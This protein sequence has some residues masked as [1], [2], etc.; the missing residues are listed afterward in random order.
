MKFCINCGKKLDDGIMFCTGCGTRVEEPKPASAPVYVPMTEMYL[1][2]D[3]TV[4]E[5]PAAK[6]AAAPAPKPA[7]EP[8]YAYQPP[9]APV[10]QPPVQQPVAPAPKKPAA[11]KKKG[12]K[13]PLVLA[14]AGVALLVVIAVVVLLL[15]G[16][17][18]S[19]QKAVLGAFKKTIEAH[20][21][22]AEGLT[23]DMEAFNALVESQEYNQSIDLKIKS[24]PYY[25]ELSGLVVIVDMS[26]IMPQKVIGL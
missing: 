13:A 2:A 19:D 15:S 16:V 11:P 23:L 3:K 10:Y 14:I 7:Y 21:E 22:A 5:R 24:V 9:V 6:P 18:V 4:V 1:D 17:F 12:S 26:Y 25:E 8:K 20:T